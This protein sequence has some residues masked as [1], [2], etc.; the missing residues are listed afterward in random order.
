MFFIDQAL[1]KK[2]GMNASV[3]IYLDNKVGREGKKLK[4]SIAI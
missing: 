1:V 4:I 2:Y 3:L